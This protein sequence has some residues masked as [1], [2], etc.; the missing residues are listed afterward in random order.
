[1]NHLQ[2]GISARLCQFMYIQ[3]EHRFS[4][5]AKES[6]TF[7]CAPEEPFPDPPTTEAT[8]S[9]TRAFYA[10]SV[11]VD[12]PTS[13]Y[14]IPYCLSLVSPSIFRMT[15]SLYSPLWILCKSLDTS[16]MEVLDYG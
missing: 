11:S 15:V 14:C 4:L 3:I 12:C 1:M 2:T 10:F 6:P 7:E 9:V 16:S 5:G 8:F 13:N